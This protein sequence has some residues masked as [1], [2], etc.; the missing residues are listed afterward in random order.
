MVRHWV[1]LAVEEA[2]K[3]EER[4]KEGRHQAALLYANDGMV[5][6]AGS[7]WLQWSFN[8]L[9]GLFERV[10]LRTNVGMAVSMTCRPL[11]VAG[12]QLDL[13]YGRKMTGEGP[14]YRVR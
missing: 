14:T 10:S 8:S 3:R 4:G 13:A 11:P 5:A 1:A 7:R 2:E 12:K 9:V 6:S